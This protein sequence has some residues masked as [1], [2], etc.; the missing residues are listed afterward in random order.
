MEIGANTCIDRAKTDST[1]IRRGVKLDN[2]IQIAH[3]VQIGENTVASAQLG[4]AGSTKVGR[5][6]FFGGQVGIVDHITVG[7]RV[8][9]SS[10]TGLDNNVGDDEKRSGWPSMPSGKYRRSNA[11]F[12]NLPELAN[13][14][15]RLQKEV[16]ELK[17]EK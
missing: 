3:N 12:R 7:D 11:V 6:C 4:V 16:A 13:D 9:A 14:V 17:K 1:I 2:L 10:K 15:Y 5:N 8:M